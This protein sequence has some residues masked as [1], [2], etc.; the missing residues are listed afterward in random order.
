MELSNNDLKET[1]A[2]L[3]K[4]KEELTRQLREGASGV[5]DQYIKEKDELEERLTKEKD[6]QLE[7]YV[8]EDK[9]L[10]EQLEGLMEIRFVLLLH[11][12][13]V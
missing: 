9:A 7:K 11:L 1:I 10:R 13:L 4:E 3:M 8:K 6:E 12:F 2:S 5:I